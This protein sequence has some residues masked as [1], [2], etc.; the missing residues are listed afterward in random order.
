MRINSRGTRRERRTAG[1][2]SM[3]PTISASM[4]VASPAT[5]SES[6]SAFEA[7][8]T[9]LSVKDSEL[10]VHDCGAAVAEYDPVVNYLLPRPRFLRYDP[11][12]RSEV[13]RRMQSFEESLDSEMESSSSQTGDSS[14]S[15]SME[16]L[17]FIS[18]RSEELSDGQT[19]LHEEGAIG[20]IGMVGVGEPT[21]QQV[22]VEGLE[23]E[24]EDDDDDDEEKSR[25]SW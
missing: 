15:S 16:G 22:V 20:L 18:C 21:R 13:L 2:A 17:D 11:N 5:R 24:E 10:E 25:W 6:E 1:E 8:A 4:K 14:S 7:T 23:L 3:S 9:P 12:R 19:L